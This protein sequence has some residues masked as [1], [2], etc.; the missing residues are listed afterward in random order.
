MG[1]GIRFFGMRLTFRRRI[2][3]FVM[4]LAQRDYIEPVFLSIAEVVMVLGRAIAIRV[5]LRALKCPGARQSASSNGIVDELPG[6]ASFG[7]SGI[8]AVGCRFAMWA[9]VDALDALAHTRLAPI[10][11]SIRASTVTAKRGEWF[12][13]IALGAMLDRIRLGGRLGAHLKLILS[14]ATPRLF[15]QR[16][17]FVCSGL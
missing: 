10:A 6:L 12:V 3:E 17:A 11:K 9:V 14:G 16:G 2:G 5:S 7:V 1:F 15:Q 13:L 8:G 4:I